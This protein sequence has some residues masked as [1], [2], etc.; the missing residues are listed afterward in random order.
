M[1]TIRRCWT[2]KSPLVALLVLA[3][4]GTWFPLR[5]RPGPQAA[6]LP[7]VE[8][9]G[10]FDVPVSH[11]EDWI[12]GFSVSHD[13]LCFLAFRPGGWEVIETDTEGKRIR[14]LQPPP[15]LL[16]AGPK[17]LRAS[18]S[19]SLAALL[20]QAK[21]HVVCVFSSG[22]TSSFRTEEAI[23]DLQFSRRQL[24]AI[25]YRRM[26]PVWA[27]SGSAGLRGETLTGLNEPFPTVAVPDGRIGF[28]R[29][30]SGYYCLADPEAGVLD[31]PQRLLAPEFREASLA[32]KHHTGLFGHVAAS[33]DGRIYCDLGGYRV[34]EGAVVAEFDV[35][36]SFR[37][38]FRLKLPHFSPLFRRRP[39][40][41]VWVADRFGYVTPTDMAVK[42][43]Y[44][45]VL[46]YGAR[47]VA[48]YEIPR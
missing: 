20:R 41:A 43:G 31:P 27:E 17:L 36:G 33:A 26:F 22:R 46:D 14:A 28:L 45:Y 16:G 29:P 35:D 3:L 15:E 7:P 4:F 5:G 18:P 2:S 21:Q 24:L 48:W 25:N 34:Q 32:E 39:G 8:P 10:W 40:A 47:K 38:S 30:I 1:R 6:G 13:T 12:L 37:R 11:S 44:L 9:E 23:V 19:G 42:G